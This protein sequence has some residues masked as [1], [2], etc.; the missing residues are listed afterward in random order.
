MQA[1]ARAIRE[2]RTL[3]AALDAGALPSF[4]DVTVVEALL[5]GLLRQ[6]VTK[7]LAILGHGNS[8][9]A[10]LILHF[11]QGRKGSGGRLLWLFGLGDLAPGPALIK[12]FVVAQCFFF[13]PFCL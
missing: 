5:L 12:G 10:A 9:F 8:S 1:R 6:G 11:R 7:Y 4:V 2:H 3:A 13:A